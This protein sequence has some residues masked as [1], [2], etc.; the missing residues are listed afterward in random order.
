M[1]LIGKFGPASA[2]D[3]AEWFGLKGTSQFAPEGHPS[4][5]VQGHEVW[6]DPKRPRFS[7]RTMTRC[8]CGAVLPVGRLAQHERSAKHAATLLGRTARRIPEHCADCGKSGERT[9]H[10]DCQF[11]GDH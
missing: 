7:L 3:V 6:V 5:F 4:I 9:G 10:Q 8:S 11:P 1:A 2:R